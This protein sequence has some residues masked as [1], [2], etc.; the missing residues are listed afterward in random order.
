MRIHASVKAVSY[1]LFKESSRF[2]GPHT[3][4]F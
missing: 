3:L 2:G 1:V 4:H